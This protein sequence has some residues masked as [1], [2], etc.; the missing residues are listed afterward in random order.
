MENGSR[1]CKLFNHMKN[2]SSK[3]KNQKQN[4]KTNPKFSRNL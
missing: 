1:K 2:R 3:K 4:Q